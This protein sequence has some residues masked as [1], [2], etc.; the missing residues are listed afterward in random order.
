MLLWV[1]MYWWIWGCLYWLL[2]SFRNRYLW[3]CPLVCSFYI[4]VLGACRV[5]G[6][7]HRKG[8]MFQIASLQHLEVP[9][10]NIQDLML[11]SRGKMHS[12]L[13][14]RYKLA[15]CEGREGRE[16]SWMLCGYD[17]CSDFTP[18]GWAARLLLTGIAAWK[19]LLDVGYFF[20]PWFYE[21]AVI[22][23]GDCIVSDQL[24]HLDLGKLRSSPFSIRRVIPGDESTVMF[25]LKSVAQTLL[26]S[27]AHA[28]VPGLVFCLEMSVCPMCC[29]CPF[30]VWFSRALR[31]CLYQPQVTLDGKD[32]PGYSAGTWTLA[33]SKGLAVVYWQG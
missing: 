7:M 19:S 32:F 11:F 31:T 16:F 13:R 27:G 12:R 23:L 28:A 14:C 17:L 22:V 18:L 21:P 26:Q 4:C 1:N 20:S 25:A 2:L 10:S 8:W 3:P 30:Q 24:E 29:R 33:G 9:G 15:P 5:S 6:H